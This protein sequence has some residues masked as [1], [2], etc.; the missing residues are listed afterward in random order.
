MPRRTIEVL[1]DD[2]DGKELPDDTQPVRLTVNRTTYNLYL[3][4]ANYGKLLE[5]LN[6]FTEGAET[7]ASAVS[8]KRARNS[9]GVATTVNT[10][11]YPVADVR[12]WAIKKKMK[13]K[14]GAP[15]TEATR[16]INQDIYDAYKAEQDRS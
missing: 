3:S 5:A 15:I 6:P 11:G 14:S 1:T 10:Y 7:A 13:A 8:R 2:L 4:D 16:R 9:S 12:A